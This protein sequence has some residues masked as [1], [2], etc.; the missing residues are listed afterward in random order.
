ML[1]KWL[2]LDGFLKL[3]VL[4][5]AEAERYQ[6]SLFCDQK[7]LNLHNSANLWNILTP[8]TKIY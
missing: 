5:K 2:F 1:V 6:D 7:A 4:R 3:N 8:I